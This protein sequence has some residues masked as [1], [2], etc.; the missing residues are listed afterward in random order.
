MSGTYLKLNPPEI[1]GSGYVLKINVLNKEDNQRT[2]H[3]DNDL[4]IRNNNSAVFNAS[5]EFGGQTIHAT[6]GIT[7]TQ[8][9]FNQTGKYEISVIVEG[10]NFF[11]IKPLFVDFTATV[12]NTSDGGSRVVISS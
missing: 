5:S 2:R 4:I 7:L 12:T 11:P 6:N 3:V 9:N 10:L 8:F 1:K